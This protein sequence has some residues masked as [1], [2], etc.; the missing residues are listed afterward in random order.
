MRRALTLP[1]PRV[2]GVPPSALQS[3]AAGA[4]CVSGL[5]GIELDHHSVL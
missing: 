4:V 2:S 1:P 5:S 3:A